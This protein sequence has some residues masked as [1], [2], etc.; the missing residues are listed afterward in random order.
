MDITQLIIDDHAEQRR[1][2]AAIDEISPHDTEALE[3]VW[4]RLKALLDSHAEAEERY[5]YPELLKLGTG[6]TDADSADEET[7]DAI[8]DHNDIRD[9]GEEVQKHEIGSPEWFSAIDAC[10]VAN[11][12]HMGEEERQGLTDFRRNA[13]FELR[14]KLAVRFLAF[15][16]A[17]LTGVDVADKNPD[18]YIEDPSKAVRDAHG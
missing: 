2:F 4:V 16:C 1:L 6:A 12:D 10:N 13:S 17:H 11:S 9:T 18:D 5:F 3:S 14:H 7:Q 8:E 15:Q